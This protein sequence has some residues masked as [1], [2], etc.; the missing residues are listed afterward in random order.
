MLPV[1]FSFGGKKGAARSARESMILNIGAI[2]HALNGRLRSGRLRRSHNNP[3]ESAKANM[4]PG[5][6][7]TSKMNEYTSL[8]GGSA[9]TRSEG[10]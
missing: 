9:M 5:Y 4:V 1:G 7:S 2:V 6:P 8:D 3:I 10:M